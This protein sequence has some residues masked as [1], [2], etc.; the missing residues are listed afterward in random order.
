MV[1]VDGICV[2]D[3]VAVD[4][5]GVYVL[6]EFADFEGGV[7]VVADGEGHRARGCRLSVAPPTHQV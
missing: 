1:E 3:V 7:V 2:E 4:C 6:V 5:R